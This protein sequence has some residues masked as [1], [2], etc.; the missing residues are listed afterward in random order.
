MQ[1]HTNATET[2]LFSGENWFTA[3]VKLFILPLASMCFCVGTAWK[4][5]SICFGGNML[6]LPS[7][8]TNCWPLHTHPHPRHSTHYFTDSEHLLSSTQPHNDLLLSTLYCDTIYCDT[9][10]V[11]LS[12][13]YI[14]SPASGSKRG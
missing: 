14:S 9:N 12:E 8:L 7:Q 1:N 11:F 3:F 2:N 10:D 4:Q 6:H 13:P 5:L